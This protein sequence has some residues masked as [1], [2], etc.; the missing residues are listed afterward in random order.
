M[1][2]QEHPWFPDGEN[3]TIDLE[4][5]NIPQIVLL[6]TFGMT[7]REH[8]WFP[9]DGENSTINLYIHNSPQIVLLSTL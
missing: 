8:P 5:H 7:L 1:T 3:S 2:L 6:S 9:P 4:I